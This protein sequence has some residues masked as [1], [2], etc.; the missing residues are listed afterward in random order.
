MVELYEFLR[1]NYVEDSDNTFRFDY[2]IEFLK[3]ALLV[4]GQQPEWLLGVRYGKKKVL[5]GFISAIP[6]SV[7]VK[8]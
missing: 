7:V 3:W 1:D 5:Y 4:P 8:G 2:P 6:V